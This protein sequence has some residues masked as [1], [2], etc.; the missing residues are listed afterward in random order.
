MARW[1]YPLRAAMC[2]GLLL[3]GTAN[4]LA[5]CGTSVD[6]IFASGFGIGPSIS[7]NMNEFV[8][9]PPDAAAKFLPDE[10]S[11]ASR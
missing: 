3:A 6:P 10:H 4:A 1:R 7:A 11:A 2:M 9:P 8:L 5:P